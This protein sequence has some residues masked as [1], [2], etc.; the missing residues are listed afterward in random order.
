MAYT[1]TLS[2][3]CTQLW[4][5]H[6]TLGWYVC[7]VGTEIPVTYCHSWQQRLM[8]CL[9]QW[10]SPRAV[11][12]RLAGIL[13]TNHTA[14]NSPSGVWCGVTGV[15]HVHQKPLYVEVCFYVW[16]AFL[17]N[18]FYHLV[19]KMFVYFFNSTLVTLQEPLPWIERLISKELSLTEFWLVPA[20]C[21]WTLDPV[22][23]KTIVV[24]S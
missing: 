16:P 20:S 21:Q 3:F 2:F 11:K 22:Y 5:Y 4:F 19:M 10:L 13:N 15:N 24:V 9:L 23:I 12:T 1:R 8:L 18:H 17:F 7:Q 14:L 6:E